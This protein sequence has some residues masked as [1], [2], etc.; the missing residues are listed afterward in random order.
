[1]LIKTTNI[2]FKVWLIDWWPIHFDKIISADLFATQE[3]AAKLFQMP[4]MELGL[5]L[6][7]TPSHTPAPTAEP[8]KG[9]CPMMAAKL[10]PKVFRFK[11]NPVLINVYLEFMVLKCI[12]CMQ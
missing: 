12:L 4:E 8:A 5:C 9:F 2:L 11:F 3:S 10:K 1:M 7:H 6:T